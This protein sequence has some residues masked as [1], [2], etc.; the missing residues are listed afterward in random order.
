MAEHDRQQS[1]EGGFGVEP[2]CGR[3]GGQAVL[4]QLLDGDVAAD[5]TCRGGLGQEVGDHPA[6]A[7]VRG[8]RMLVL[9][10]RG[11]GVGVVEHS[12]DLI[13]RCDWIVDLGPGGGV[14]GGE[15]LYSGPL[16]PF[17][18]EGDSPTSEELRRHL[19]WPQE[20]AVAAQ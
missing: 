13:A 4:G 12:P 10:Q 1:S 9:V 14:H 6:Q 16:E 2:T 18:D 17:L 8:R 19:K 7:L 15:V 11:D 5:I 20:A 3:Q